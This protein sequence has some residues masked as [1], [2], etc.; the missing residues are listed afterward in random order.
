[1]LGETLQIGVGNLL[2]LLASLNGSLLDLHA[3]LRIGGIYLRK[4]S[5]IAVHRPLGVLGER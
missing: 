4:R 1:M 5:L 3:G 2:L